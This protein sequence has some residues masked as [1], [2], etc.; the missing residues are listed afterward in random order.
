MNVIFLSVAKTLLFLCLTQ[1]L[2]LSFLVGEDYTSR[3]RQQS[4]NSFV[5][6]IKS[7]LC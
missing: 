3:P 2:S 1:S 5:M 7:E 6:T 4:C